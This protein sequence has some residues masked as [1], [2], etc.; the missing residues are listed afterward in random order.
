MDNKQRE[1]LIKAYNKG[2]T[3]YILQ[4]GVLSWGVS[5]AIIYRILVSLFNIG[6]SFSAIKRG[7]FSLDTLYAIPLFSIGGL[8]WGIFMW[9]IIEKKASEIKE[10]RGKRR[11]DREET[12]L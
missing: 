3:K 9:K 8:L 7:L 10:K 11:K 5:T 6:F 2:K 1:N 12:I 4:H